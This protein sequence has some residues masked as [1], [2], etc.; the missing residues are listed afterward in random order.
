VPAGTSSYPHGVCR[1]SRGAMGLDTHAA[2]PLAEATA[3]P[4]GAA[5]AEGQRTA[6]RQAHYRRGRWGQAEP[7][8]TCLAAGR[9]L[10][11]YF[12]PPVLGMSAQSWFGGQEAWK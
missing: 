8:S 10:G 4:T 5:V 11:S 1:L 2:G 6:R 12:R 7:R 3:A 9:H